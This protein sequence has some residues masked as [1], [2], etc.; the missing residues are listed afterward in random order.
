MRKQSIAALIVA[1]ALAIPAGC[2]QADS[3]GTT[4]GAQSVGP[5]STSPTSSAT[6]TEQASA[7][8]ADRGVT[9]HVPTRGH[10]C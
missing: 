9:G 5:T 4:Q 3:T 1:A 6:P 10:P 2:A 7:P 8:D